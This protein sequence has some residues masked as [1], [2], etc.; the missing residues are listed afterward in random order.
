MSMSVLRH[1]WQA[2]FP[3]AGQVVEVWYSVA[4]ILAVWTGSEWHTADG[5]RLADNVSHWR[6]RQ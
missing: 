6:F 1:A 5:Q 3:P 4:I 2:G